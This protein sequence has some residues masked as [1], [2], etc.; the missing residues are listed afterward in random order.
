MHLLVRLNSTGTVPYIAKIPYSKV[1]VL[2]FAKNCFNTHVLNTRDRL[3]IKK[4]GLVSSIHRTNIVTSG[5][6]VSVRF[7]SDE[8]H[9]TPYRTVD[10]CTVYARFMQKTLLLVIVI[11]LIEGGED[12]GKERS[13][14]DGDGDGDV[15][16]MVYDAPYDAVN[17]GRSA[18]LGIRDRLKLDTIKPATTGRH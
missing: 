17:F 6:D 10:L 2:Y 15:Q 18:A 1:P 7:A 3:I 14:H 8:H 11:L 16:A 12:E 13:E 9:S 5:E 4:R